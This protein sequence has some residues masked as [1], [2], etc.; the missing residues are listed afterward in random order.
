MNGK[1]YKTKV[2]KNSCNLYQ[3]SCYPEYSKEDCPFES[4]NQIEFKDQLNK[5]YGTSMWPNTPTLEDLTNDLNQL[6][7]LPDLSFKHPETSKNESYV[8]QANEL[9]EHFMPL[10][11][12]WVN[13]LG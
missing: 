2:E 8:I 9:I 11:N 6:I 5:K 4:L 12:G 13:C 10:V 7:T 1:T 3:L